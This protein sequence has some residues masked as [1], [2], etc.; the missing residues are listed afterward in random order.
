MA[1]PP[2]PCASMAAVPKVRSKRQFN[3]HPVLSHNPTM[4]VTPGIPQTGNQC[5]R[6][7]MLR[8]G[9]ACAGVYLPTHLHHPP[10]A[11]PQTR[12]HWRATSR[13]FTVGSQL[14]VDPPPVPI[15]PGFVQKWVTP[16]QRLVLSMPNP[17]MHEAA[18]GGTWPVP[19]CKSAVA[20]HDHPLL[21]R[22]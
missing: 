22:V 4:A 18:R 12:P 20:H 3:A 17:D 5:S 7:P 14:N 9:C 21:T 13:S 19:F 2:P 10:A 11:L 8:Q 16:R 1:L 15:H 6:V